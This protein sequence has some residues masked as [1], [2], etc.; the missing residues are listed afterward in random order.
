MTS[1]SFSFPVLCLFQKVVQTETLLITLK[2]VGGAKL[3]LKDNNKQKWPK[4]GS[5]KCF[6]LGLPITKKV[7]PLS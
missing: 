1:V 4:C 6:N 2:W 3:N 5:I 7:G